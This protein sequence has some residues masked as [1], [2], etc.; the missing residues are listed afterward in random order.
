MILL[1][2]VP[3]LIYAILSVLASFDCT[4]PANREG[5]EWLSQMDG[6]R[7]GAFE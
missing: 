5:I 7:F 1:L 6:K 4:T 2:E 3:Y